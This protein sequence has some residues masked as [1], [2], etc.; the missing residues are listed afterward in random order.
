MKYPLSLSAPLVVVACLCASFAPGAWGTAS[1][2]SLTPEERGVQS[3]E[4]A[5][6]TI[7]GPLRSFLRMA[8]ISQKVSPEEVMPFLA[9]N[10]FLLGYESKASKLQPTEFLISAKTIRAAG[11]RTG[12]FGWDWRRYSCLELRRR[13]AIAENPRLPALAGVRPKRHFPRDRRSAKGVSY[14]RLRVPAGRTR[15]DRTGRPSLSLTHSPILQVP[16]F[17]AESDW[18]AVS[19]EGGKDKG[20][21]AL[22]DALLHDPALARLYD[23]W[24]RIDSETQSV[25]A[26]S[27]GLRK[28]HPYAASLDFYGSYIRIRSGRVLVPGGPVAESGWKDLVG[29][30]PQSPGEFV[31]RLI[32]KDNGWLAAYFDSLSRV[33]PEQQAHFVESPRLRRCYEALRGK[34]NSPSATGVGVSA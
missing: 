30:S 28:L 15:E 11:K 3:H 19:E 21:G 14:D 13:E 27:L 31:L 12:S 23:A 22:L 4:A 2:R 24:A 18:T 17:L 25:L 10:I 9:R 8:G 16:I 20:S 6:A 32:A 33:P 26:R 7:P 34:T 29:V 1:S 5:T